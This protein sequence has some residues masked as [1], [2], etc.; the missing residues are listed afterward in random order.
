VHIA[1]LI[2]AAIQV[3]RHLMRMDFTNRKIAVPIILF[4]QEIAFAHGLL[5]V[6]VMENPPYACP[7][8]SPCQPAYAGSEWVENSTLKSLQSWKS[9]AKDLLPGN[10][11]FSLLL[12]IS[13]FP[14]L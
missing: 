5:R 7:D 12:T 10:I 14:F 9:K 1:D 6:L 4:I 11:R 2:W 8:W 13:T 3:L